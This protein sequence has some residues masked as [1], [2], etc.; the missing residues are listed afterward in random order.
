MGKS[1]QSL[2]RVQAL[3]LLRGLAVAGMI[4]VDSPGDWNKVYAP[5][6]HAAWNGWTPTDLVFPTFLFCV[7]MAWALSFPRSQPAIPNL[8]LRI[9]KR[10]TLLILIGLFL[11][12]LPYFDL[13]HLRIPGILQRIAICY[14]LTAALTLSTGR[15]RDGMLHVNA[16]AMAVAAA[17][18]LL[19]YWA[20]LRFVPTPGYGPG[21]LDSLRALPA[22]MDRIIFS[23]DHIWKQGTTVGVGVTYDPEGILSTMGAVG[24]C[25]A[26][27]LA[28]VAIRK[29]PRHR[30]IVLFAAA[31]AALIG[32][33]YLLDPVLP[34]NKRLWTSSFTVA[35]SGVALLLLAGLL[36][37]PVRSMVTAVTWPLKVLGANAIL[38]FIISQLLGV[39]SALKFVP[40]NHTV[41]TPQGWG[42][43]IA[44]DLIADPYLASLACASGVLLIIL[45]MIVPLHRRGVFL[46]V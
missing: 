16:A 5:L 19:C 21:H 45:L 8:W 15:R 29:L 13:T 14:F 27:V 43:T 36:L 10:T 1:K 32:L 18:L 38:A 6:Q 24:N 46:R 17:V 7:G 42:N 26:G 35:T 30:S 11:N 33:G 9:F 41:V 4:I 31:G 44:T 25:L 39:L 22:W 12:A 3:D 23:T 37:L 20:L 2:E 34:I 40:W 28:A